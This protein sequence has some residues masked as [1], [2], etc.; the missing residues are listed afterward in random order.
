MFG[1]KRGGLAIG[2]LFLTGIWAQTI[3][4]LSD[5]GQY[6]RSPALSPAGKI[7]AFESAKTDYSLWIFLQPFVGGQASTFAS[8]EKIAGSPTSPKWSPD[9]NHI[10]FLRFYCMNCNHRLFVKSYPHGSEHTLGDVCSGPPSW[11]P[12][13]HFLVAAEPVGDNEN[14]RIALIPVDGSPRRVIVKGQSNLVAVSPDGKRMA[15]TSGNRLNFANLTADYHLADAPV[16]IAEEPHAI[17]SINWLPNGQALVYQVWSDANLYSKL[18]LMEALRQP[19]QL[20]DPGAN[21]EL[22][23]ILAD[24]TALGT[25]YGGDSTLWRVDLQATVQEPVKVRT[26]PWTDQ[27]LAVSPDAQLL[28]FATNRNGPTQIWISRLDGGHPRVLVSKIPPFGAYGDN[29]AVD[30]I[31]WSPDGKWIAMRTQPGIGHGDD[32]ARLF[33]V[34]T[35]GGRPRELAECS[36]DPD[37]PP[38]SDDSQS[39]FIAK[40][41]ENSRS[42]YFRVDISTRKQT[43]VTESKLPISPR[44]VWPLPQGARQPHLSQGGRYLYYQDPPS[45]KTRIVAIRKFLNI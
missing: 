1:H 8:S 20:L 35:P 31:S 14:C 37:A 15:Y 18:V 12:D 23:Q 29:T 26:I 42:T 16:A 32:S 30:G 43:E 33:L 44:S 19:S 45:R 13:G 2:F 36:Q 3:S 10:A 25:Q 6:I 5:F 7:L 27:L 39:V 11:T 38:W 41:D 9:G 24:G 21:I 34:P 28:A 17:A 40:T 22:S 4:P